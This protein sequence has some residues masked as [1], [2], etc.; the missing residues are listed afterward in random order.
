MTSLKLRHSLFFKVWF[1][2]NQFEKPQF[3]QITLLEVTKI[4]D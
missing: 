3:G 4:E 1:R 2:N